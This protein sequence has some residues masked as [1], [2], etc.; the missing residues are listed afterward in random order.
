MCL[1]LEN[2]ENYGVPGSGCGVSPSCGKGAGERG[3]EGRRSQEI[4]DVCPEGSV[5]DLKKAVK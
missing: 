1:C 3:R 4:Q 2:D 5:K